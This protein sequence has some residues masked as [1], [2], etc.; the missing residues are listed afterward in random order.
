MSSLFTSVREP[1]RK[2]FPVATWLKSPNVPSPLPGSSKIP[3]L[4]GVLIGFFSLGKADR[5]SFPSW[6]SHPL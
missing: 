1:F 2:K 4:V 3:H 5:S 6:F